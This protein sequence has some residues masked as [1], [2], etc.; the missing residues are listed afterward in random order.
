MFPILQSVKHC[1]LVSAY[2]PGN[3]T[4]KTD[5]GSVFRTTAAH[6]HF[7]YGCSTSLKAHLLWKPVDNKVSAPF[8]FTFIFLVC[9][10]SWQSLLTLLAERSGK[11]FVG[12][13]SKSCCHLL[14]EAETKKSFILFPNISFLLFTFFSHPIVTS[15][16]FWFHRE[17]SP[18]ISQSILQRASIFHCPFGVCLTK[19]RY[20]VELSMTLNHAH[21]LISP[22][23][24][25]QRN[26]AVVS[27]RNCS[28]GLSLDF[29]FPLTSLWETSDY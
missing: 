29:A 14:S 3:D 4:K 6:C 5:R 9:Q 12:K 1:S 10:K 21:L 24:C 13:T 20:S 15:P 8:Y 18:V 22:C 16:R 28:P 7:Q 11:T 19:S 25:C 26:A 27:F 2:R 17:L 23:L